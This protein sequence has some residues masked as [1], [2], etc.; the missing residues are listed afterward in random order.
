MEIQVGGNQRRRR[1]VHVVDNLPVTEHQQHHRHDIA[2]GKD[3]DGVRPR[4]ERPVQ[5]AG[6][7]KRLHSITSPAEQR[8]HTPQQTIAVDRHQGQ[9]HAPLVDV[10]S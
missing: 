5:A 7:T 10:V 3:A 4:D 8:R 2:E 6:K 9:Q 1:L